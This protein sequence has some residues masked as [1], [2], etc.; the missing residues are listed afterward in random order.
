MALSF[1][2]QFWASAHRFTSTSTASTL[3]TFTNA[4]TSPCN[5]NRISSGPLADL[6]NIHTSAGFEAPNEIDGNGFTVF[7]V[8]FGAVAFGSEP[9]RT[10]G[11]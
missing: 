9:L 6:L 4:A 3:C 5:T 8:P 7:R 2:G 11:L 1:R 10:W